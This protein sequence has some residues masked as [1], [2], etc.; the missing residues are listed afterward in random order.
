[1]FGLTFGIMLAG[2]PVFLLGGV[3]VR[4]AIVRGP[5]EESWLD[6]LLETNDPRAFLGVVALVV[7]YP[8]IAIRRSLSFLPYGVL[9]LG[10]FMA[11]GPMLYWGW[12]H[13]QLSP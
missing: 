13:G 9:L 6:T 10:I 4:N 8:S 2:F 5:H 7:M 3:L 12:W 11:F 1:M